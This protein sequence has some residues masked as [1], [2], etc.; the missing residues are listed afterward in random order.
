[1]NRMGFDELSNFRINWYVDVIDFSSIK[2][3]RSFTV[4]KNRKH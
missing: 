1:M 2:A 4:K 3:F